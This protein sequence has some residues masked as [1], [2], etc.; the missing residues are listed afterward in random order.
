[1]KATI[2]KSNGKKALCRGAS[3]P[4]TMMLMTLMSFLYVKSLP[5]MKAAVDQARDVA[6]QANL[7]AIDQAKFMWLSNPTNGVV[8]NDFEPT[9]RDIAPYLSV[10]GVLITETT[11]TNLLVRPELS[12]IHINK[13][14]TPPTAE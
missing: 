5:L 3:I 2:A 6:M 8:G 4:Q 1:M 10:R 13:I 11:W 9:W 14:G 7:K 12:K